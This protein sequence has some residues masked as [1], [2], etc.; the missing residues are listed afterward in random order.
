M[1]LYCKSNRDGRQIG[2]CPFAQFIQLVMQKKGI[3][4]NVIPTLP[5]RRPDWILEEHDGRM[6]VIL[7]KIND[8]SVS[9]P[10][11][12]AKYIEDLYPHA[13][14][15]KN[16]TITYHDVLEKTSNFYPTLTKFLLNTK[17]ENDPVL[18]KEMEA[19]LELIDEILRSTP[20]KYICG[21]DCNLAD[22]YLTPLLWNAMVSIDV[23][24]KIEI[25][26]MGTDPIRPALERYMT[27]MFYMKEF[28]DKRAYCHIDKIVYGWKVLRGEAPPPIE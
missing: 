17:E 13:S 27:D 16:G 6:P 7:N 22:L 25:L 3:Q 2:D 23:F 12:I 18:W 15:I 19:Q 26:N 9:D 1:E 21:I 4:Y 14:L 28:N 24:K 8:E 10:I 11:A 20:G 5:S